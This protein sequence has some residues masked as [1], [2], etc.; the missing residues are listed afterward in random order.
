M[1]KISLQS[2][3]VSDVY[4]F[5]WH[6]LNEHFFGIYLFFQNICLLPL[7]LSLICYLLAYATDLGFA[8]SEHLFGFVLSSTSHC[9]LCVFSLLF[10]CFSQSLLMLLV[11]LYSCAHL[12][13]SLHYQH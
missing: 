6:F 11:P 3:E 2:K 9:L 10:S 4:D 5:L 12:I 13:M 8:S 7:I 1:H